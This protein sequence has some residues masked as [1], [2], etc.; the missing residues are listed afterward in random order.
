MP[1]WT[2]EGIPALVRC[3]KVRGRSL[4]RPS[5]DSKVPFPTRAHPGLALV[6][7]LAAIASACP[8]P[9]PAP[10]PR[11]PPPAATTAPAA[12]AAEPPPPAPKVVVDDR[13][14][15]RSPAD[16]ALKVIVEQHASTIAARLG[17][18]PVPADFEGANRCL[19]TTTLPDVDGDGAGE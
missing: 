4:M 15:V 1:P 10:P 2:R 11:P 6:A 5:H 9:P 16:H 18:A 19:S 8:A 13:G 12:T 14:C 7:S 3:S 17:R